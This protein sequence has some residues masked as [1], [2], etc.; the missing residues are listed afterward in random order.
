MF[1]ASHIDHE[2]KTRLLPSPA[3][4]P[5]LR[6]FATCSLRHTTPVVPLSTLLATIASY[7]PQAESAST[8]KRQSRLARVQ[9][10]VSILT[11]LYARPLT[12]SS[13]QANWNARS[14]LRLLVEPRL[15][16][17]IYVCDLSATVPYQENISGHL[18]TKWKPLRQ[19]CRQLSSEITAI[20][21]AW[22]TFRVVLSIPARGLFDLLIIGYSI[23]RTTVEMHVDCF[24][25]MQYVRN[26]RKEFSGRTKGNQTGIL[27]PRLQHVVVQMSGNTAPR[28]KLL[29][30]AEK[31]LREVFGRSELESVLH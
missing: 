26:F 24:T 4:I 15:K 20:Q 21:D 18:N 28:E 11:D 25:I 3:T 27:F 2:V 6:R 10:H 29:S 30:D 13:T 5:I 1:A 9:Y 22:N 7:P 23:E 8:T 19:T 12:L 16:I 14:L 17:Y 31:F